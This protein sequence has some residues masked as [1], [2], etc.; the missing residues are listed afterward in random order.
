MN[1]QDT[2]VR[3]REDETWKLE[4][5]GKTKTRETTCRDVWRDTRLLLFYEAV[6]FVACGQFWP[7]CRTTCCRNASTRV[8]L[9]MIDTLYIG[10][11]P[12]GNCLY[13]DV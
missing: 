7:D 8:F 11:N 1:D 9:M 2:V 6:R 3:L 12:C 10:V 13:S 5:E 4:T